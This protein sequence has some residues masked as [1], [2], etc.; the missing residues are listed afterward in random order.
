MHRLRIDAGKEESIKGLVGPVPSVE[1]I[2]KFGKIGVAVF[3]KDSVI[4]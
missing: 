1:A 3:G 2:G 4:G